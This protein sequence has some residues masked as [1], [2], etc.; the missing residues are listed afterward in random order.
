MAN[1]K[2]RFA[3]VL[4]KG[5]IKR[6]SPPKDVADALEAAVK[7][8]V[9]SRMN[10]RTAVNKKISEHM[11][12]INRPIQDLVRSGDKQ[13]LMRVKEL[14][15]LTKNATDLASAKPPPIRSGLSP[16]LGVIPSA[17]QNWFVPPWDLT[18]ASPRSDDDP[19]PFVGAWSDAVS[20]NCWCS[21]DGSYSGQ[22]YG[23]GGN[24]GASAG[25]GVWL[26]AEVDVNVILYPDMSYAY[27]LDGRLLV[28]VYGTQ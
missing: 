21:T 19:T 4:N 25:F 7:Q 9:F 3:D 13:L 23:S 20:G 28:G 17:G 2:Q 12:A 10:E 8:H 27:A 26:E 5:Q 1:I 18:W 15:E 16:Y 22:L 14:R 24:G 11:N 6:A